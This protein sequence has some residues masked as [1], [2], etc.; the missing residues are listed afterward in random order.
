MNLRK[1]ISPAARKQGVRHYLS[2][3]VR[4][5]ITGRLTNKVFINRNTGKPVVAETQDAADKS[6]LQA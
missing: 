4:C 5:K 3:A 1:M 2:F 6:D